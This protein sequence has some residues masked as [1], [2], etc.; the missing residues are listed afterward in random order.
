MAA[1]RHTAHQLV[2]LHLDRIAALD[3]KG[4]MLRSI[5]EINPN[6]L[7]IADALD[8]E[9]RTNGPR[10]PLH[11]IP[12]LL[13]DNI[14]TIDMMTTAGWFRLLVRDSGRMPRKPGWPR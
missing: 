2:Q 1:G 14:D 4:P 10:G 6:A 9:R 11:G 8:D 5:L 7:M 3:Q 13:K 12:M